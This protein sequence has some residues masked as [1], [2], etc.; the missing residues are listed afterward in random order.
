[1][2]AY[3]ER[4]ILSIKHQCLDRTTFF[5]AASL[6]WAIGAD[7]DQYHTEHSHQ[8]LDNPL[9]ELLRRDVKSRH[10]LQLGSARMCRHDEDHKATRPASFMVKGEGEYFQSKPHEGRR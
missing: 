4:L 3:A 2:S 9:I 6:R 5:T 8:G 7:I 10:S 1:M